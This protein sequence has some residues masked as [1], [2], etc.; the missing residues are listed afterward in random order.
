MFYCDGFRAVEEGKDVVGGWICA[1]NSRCPIA[2]AR[3]IS[4]MITCF[5]ATSPLMFLVGSHSPQHLDVVIKNFLTTNGVLR[6]DMLSE[7]QT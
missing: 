1:K 4:K 3:S 2:S 6:F 7:T 5:Y